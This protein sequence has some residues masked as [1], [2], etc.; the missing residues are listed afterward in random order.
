[1]LADFRVLRLDSVGDSA[2]T[3][4][5]ETNATPVLPRILDAV[6]PFL[7]WTPATESMDEDDL[8][9]CHDRLLEAVLEVAA[10]VQEVR[11]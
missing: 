11:S 2:D 8:R 10:I 5:M 1:M 4:G 6:R 7:N 9:E 3:R